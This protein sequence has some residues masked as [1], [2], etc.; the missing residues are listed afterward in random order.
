MSREVVLQML[1]AQAR[2]DA[3]VLGEIFY[4]LFLAAEGLGDGAA[5]ACPRRHA[6]PRPAR[7]AAQ[8]ASQGPAAAVTCVPVTRA[9]LSGATPRRDAEAIRCGGCGLTDAAPSMSA[10]F[11]RPAGIQFQFQARKGLI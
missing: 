4:L 9:A 11:S 2:G 5:P 6:G 3:A 1:L 7:P 10:G 8:T